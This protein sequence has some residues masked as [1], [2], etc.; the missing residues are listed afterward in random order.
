MNFF[1]NSHPAE[2]SDS[3]STSN[4]HP[5]T[6]RY[7]EACDTCFCRVDMDEKVPPSWRI[8]HSESCYAFN[9][10]YDQINI[11]REIKK[12]FP[13][14]F[15]Y[16]LENYSAYCED[17][18]CIYRLY[19]EHEKPI[20]RWF[21]TKYRLYMFHLLELKSNYTRKLKRLRESKSE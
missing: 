7:R 21:D 3:V 9:D 19:W 11:L 8:Y 1:Y 10:L 17:V 12:D 6:R 16:I 20:P 18:N 4:D 15:E 2:M 5:L 13:D 14:D